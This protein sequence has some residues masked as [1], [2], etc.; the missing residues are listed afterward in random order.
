[1][2]PTQN[3]DSGFTSYPD[4]VAS[5]SVA[6]RF[7]FSASLCVAGAFT[8]CS[9]FLIFFRLEPILPGFAVGSEIVA[10]EHVVGDR[11]AF[12]AALDFLDLQPHLDRLPRLQPEVDDLDL[13]RTT[14]PG[15]FLKCLENPLSR[16]RRSC[17]R[18]K[19]WVVSVSPISSWTTLRIT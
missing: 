11:P 3:I 14:R 6:G 2:G 5:L 8:L 19:F 13:A 12:L 17:C 16:C 4:P 10:F 7:G 15:R 9:R 1:L 18:V